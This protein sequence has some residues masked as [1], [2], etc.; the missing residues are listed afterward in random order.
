MLPVVALVGRPNVG[1]S[2][3]FNALT[4]SRRALVADEPGLTRDRQYGF[5]RIGAR[6]VTLV[7][8]GGLTGE[9]EGIDARMAEQTAAAIAEADLIL[10]LVDA[11]AGLVAGDDL[12]LDRL[13]RSG[14][15]FRIVVNKIDGVDADGALADFHGLAAAAPIA[16]SA[17]RHRGLRRLASELE[18]LLPSAGFDPESMQGEADE[19][20]RVAVVGR[21]NVGKSTLINRLIGEDRL[22]AF[23]AP[24][25][26][27]D[28]VEVPF[29]RDGHA[30]TL[31]D[32]A[33]LRRRG[34]VAG[35]V[36][37][38][39]AVKTLEAIRSAHVV[40][41][42]LDAHQ[43]LVEQDQHLAGHVLDAGRGLVI[44]VNKWDGLARDD[45]AR[46]RAEH[47]RRFD[48]ID[49][50]ESRY[51]SALHGTGVGR[52]LNAVVRAHA[53]A[54][55]QLPTAELSRVLE[56]AVF[57]HAPPAA[58]GGRIKLRY[59]HQ[60]GT[61]PPTIIIHGNRVGRMP[62]SYRRYLVHRFREAFDLHGTPVRIEFRAG[63]NPYAG[64]ASPR[65]GRKTRA[66]RGATQRRKG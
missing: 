27:R 39:S 45:K 62:A 65:S 11:H 18:P 29:E 2:T 6:E 12:I 4:H 46:V 30:F 15:A 13:R 53:A 44:A 9:V 41:L 52:L 42:V 61:H 37:K 59:A 23:D 32:T 19:R 60:G 3:L 43:G 17:A 7:D 26:T 56:Q 64:R 58:G 21:P 31:I 57:E 34:R 16:V 54:G 24:G 35:V 55:R 8:T 50:A 36:E 47:E 22:L 28:A 48:F 40:V 5:A 1:K 20:I 66:R 38:F 10:L 33:G 14:K 25:T 63:H 51:I 49:F